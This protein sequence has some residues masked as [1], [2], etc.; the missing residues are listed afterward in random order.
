MNILKRRAVRWIYCIPVAFI[1]S[2]LACAAFRLFSIWLQPS[3][4]STLAEPISYVVWAAS[5]VF[6]IVRLAPSHKRGT[7]TVVGVIGLIYS[8]DATWFSLYTGEKWD[9]FLMF[10]YVLGT[11]GGMWWARNSDDALDEWEFFAVPHEWREPLNKD[12]G[13]QSAESKTQNDPVPV[14]QATVSDA[15]DS[16]DNKIVP[17]NYVCTLW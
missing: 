16:A 4:I 7:A 12:Q 10:C 9:A 11:L 8:V 6:F 2:Q 14:S 13:V 5:F 17:Y 15:G 1:G 3:L